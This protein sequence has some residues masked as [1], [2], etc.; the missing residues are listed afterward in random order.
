MTFFLIKTA[1]PEVQSR[2]LGPVF[3]PELFVDSPGTKKQ[4]RQA[5]KMTKDLRLELFKTLGV[6]EGRGRES[7][8]P[9]C[10]GRPPGRDSGIRQA[11]VATTSALVSVTAWIVQP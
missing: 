9:R 2:S 10:L 5:P 11:R 4:R 8:G 7:I 1:P 6:W 3:R